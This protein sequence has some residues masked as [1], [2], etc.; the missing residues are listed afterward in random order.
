M[1][2]NDI[3]IYIS[4]KTTPSQMNYRDCCRSCLDNITSSRGAIASP[5]RRPFHHA[6]FLDKP[7]TTEHS[8]SLLPKPYLALPCLAS[9]IASHQLIANTETQSNGYIYITC[10]CPPLMD[11]WPNQTSQS[12]ISF[13]SPISHNQHAPSA[14]G[15]SS[16]RGPLHPSP[17]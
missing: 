15:L 5:L 14:K 1:A 11:K 9:T 8:A 3:N 10:I 4:Y 2:H 12:A 13:L 17:E 16:T 6:C 7:S